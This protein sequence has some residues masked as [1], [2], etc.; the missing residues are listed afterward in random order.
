MDFTEDNANMADSATMDDS[1]AASDKENQEQP[2][3]RAP[4]RFNRYRCATRRLKQKNDRLKNALQEAK[5]VASVKS[6]WQESAKLLTP[7]QNAF[8]KMQME[9][10]GTKPSGRRFTDEQLMECLTLYYQDPRAYRHLRKLF[11]LPSP[12]SL[13]RRIECIQLRPGFHKQIM[14]VMK[15]KLVSADDHERLVSLSFDEMQVRPRLTYVR[16]DDVIEGMEDLGPLGRPVGSGRLADH[17]LVFMAR[18]VTR[19]WKQPVGYVLSQGPTPARFLKPLLETCV[20]EMRLAGFKVVCVVSDM[21]TPNQQLFKELGVS[22]SKPTF[23][24]DEEDVVALHDVPHL[25]KCLRNALMKNDIT[26]DGKTASWRHI[27]EFYAEDSKRPIRCAPKLTGLHVNPGAFKRMK[28]RYATQL[29]SRAVA[30]GLA[31]YSSCGTSCQ[32]IS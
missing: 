4:T 10:S 8:F 29:M 6:I 13:R 5:K 3:K 15:E 18:G 9:L 32:I 27:R 22:A 28:V 1:D 14:A 2:S 24:V 11:V 16:G 31:V 23:P 7:K 12:R 21:G 26:V 25:M 17:A 19:H 30:S 20:R